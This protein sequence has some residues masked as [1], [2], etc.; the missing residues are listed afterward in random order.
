MSS[1]RHSEPEGDGFEVRS[2]AATFAH[3]HVLEEHT[4]P[5]AQLVYA[6]SGV[7]RVATPSAAWLVPPTR[8]IWV[9]PGVPHAISMRGQVAMR[10]LYVTPARSGGLPTECR[11]LEVP[12]LLR[13]LI[14][15]VVGIG[16]LDPTRPDHERL[17]GLLLDLLAASET[18][19][20]SLPLPRDA[21]ARGLA[22]RILAEPGAPATFEQLARG[23]GASLR[24][25]QRLFLAE[26]GL[27]LE[28]WRTRAR[29]QH[30][31]VRLASGVA[32]TETALEA[33]YQSPSAFTAAFKRAFGV[34]PSRYRTRSSSTAR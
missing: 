26:T 21:R 16:M 6:A 17:A 34:T 14:L 10:T 15:H 1:T 32:V 5:W 28:A 22:D 20:L 31:V 30:G 13:E 33:G 4:H 18:A 11:A 12:P 2:F 23:A 7:M 24:T 19:P 29:M 27:S 8:A 9:P 3:G 25:L